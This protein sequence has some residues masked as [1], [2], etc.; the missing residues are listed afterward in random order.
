MGTYGNLALM[1]FY[2]YDLI[3]PY[4]LN[5]PYIYFVLT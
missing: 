2:K 3:I 1:R 5:Y 4:P